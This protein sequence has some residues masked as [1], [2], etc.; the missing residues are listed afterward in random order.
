MSVY[1]GF[2]AAATARDV[3][4]RVGS[5]RCSY[6]ELGPIVGERFRSRSLSP[7]DALK[8][9]DELLPQVKPASVYAI[10]QL[11]TVIAH[12]PASPSV[13]NGPALAVSLFNRMAQSGA[14]NVASDICTYNIIIACFCRMGH[15][16]LG[17]AAF[18]QI[19]KMGWRVN[20]ITFSHLLRAL[21]VEKKMNDAMDIVLW[22]MPELADVF[23]YTILLKGLCDEKKKSRGSSA[24]PYDG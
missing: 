19:L 11:L 4:R 22:R 9:F 3:S 6:S 18:C 10:N 7:D 5:G 24:A 21:C 17:F 16:D 2:S 23:S 13:R 15:L 1:C 14:K 8:L 20:T 12:A